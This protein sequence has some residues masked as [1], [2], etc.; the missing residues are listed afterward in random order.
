MSFEAGPNWII[1]AWHTLLVGMSWQPSPPRP[2]PF[3]RHLDRRGLARTAAQAGALAVSQPAGVAVPATLT[4]ARSAVTIGALDPSYF[5][6][7]SLSSL[8][9]TVLPGTPERMEVT[10]G[11]KRVA[12]LTKGARTVVLTGP[13]RTFTES[14]QSFVDDFQRTLPDTTLPV[15]D[16]KYWGTSPGGGSWSRYS[17][18]GSWPGSSFLTIRSVLDSF[19]SSRRYSSES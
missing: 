1:A 18:C 2:L 13:E 11:T 7:I 15:A 17:A 9:T 6:Q 5:T 4:S 14:K 10:S 12:L 16:R 8:T 3:T 19:R